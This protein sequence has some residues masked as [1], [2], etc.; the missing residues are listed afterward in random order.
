MV[1]TLERYAART[2]HL[3]RALLL[4]HSLIWNLKPGFVLAGSERIESRGDLG[5]RW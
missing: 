3:R 2:N 5:D 1:E 4:R